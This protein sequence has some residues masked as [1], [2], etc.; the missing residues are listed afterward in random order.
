ME[1]NK[2]NGLRWGHRYNRLYFGFKTR[3]RLGAYL[4]MYLRKDIATY[5]PREACPLLPFSLHRKM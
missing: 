4:S 5:V 3:D 1:C 2:V